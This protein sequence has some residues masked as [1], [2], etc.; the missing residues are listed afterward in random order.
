MKQVAILGNTN[1]QNRRK[2]QKTL[3]ELSFKI[4][5]LT[6]Y[7]GRQSSTNIIFLGVFLS[8]ECAPV[9]GGDFSS[10][11]VIFGPAFITVTVGTRFWWFFAILETTRQPNQE[12][13]LMSI[14]Q[15]PR[16]L[17][18]CI[19]FLSGLSHSTLKTPNKILVIQV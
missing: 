19:L 5:I 18:P 1:W 4:Y 11:K 6:S 8:V 10:L 13:K 15:T 3:T 2:V 7:F 12:K 16:R 17:S 14:S 9:P